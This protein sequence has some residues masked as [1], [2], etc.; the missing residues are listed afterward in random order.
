[1][2][3]DEVSA[4]GGAL[5]GGIIEGGRDVGSVEG[6]DVGIIDGGSFAGI[7][8]G[9]LVEGIIEVGALVGSEEG[10]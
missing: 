10:V 9:A 1:V 2:S 3:R 5:V 7:V 4:G 6:A 8:V